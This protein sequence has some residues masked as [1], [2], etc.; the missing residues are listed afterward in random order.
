MLGKPVII[1]DY[2]TSGSQLISG[3]DGIIVPMDNEA[4]AK[5]IVKVLNDT[6][7]K[8]VL[9]ENMKAKDY[10]NAKEIIKLY[11]LIVVE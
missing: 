8:N 9:V 11:E 2:S 1:T 10:T 4:C 6:K 5:G 7:L 3:F